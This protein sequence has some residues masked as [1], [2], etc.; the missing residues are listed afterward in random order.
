[1]PAAPTPATPPTATPARADARNLC[2]FDLDHTLIPI[3]S[4]HSWGDFQMTLGWV[5]GDAFKRRNDEFYA[6][7]EAG[8]LDLPT[9]IEFSTRGYRDRSKAEQ[10]AAHERFMAEVVRPAMQPAAL[11]LVRHHQDIGDLVAIITA[12]NEFVTRPIANAFGVDNLLAVE[13]ER[14]PGGTITGRIQGIPTFREGKVTRSEQWLAS[15]GR[16]W[17][18]FDRVSVY[19]DSPNDVPLLEKATDPVATNPSPTLETIARARGW[20]VLKL[21]S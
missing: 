2:L 3:D 20:R 18:D 13:L 10:D 5:D 9:Y 19:S 14:G 1:M 8:R 17:A 7:Y 15:M 21:F 12:T 11:E 16:K 6:D 4:D